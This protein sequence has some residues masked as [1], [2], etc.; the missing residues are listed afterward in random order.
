MGTDDPWGEEESSA[1]MNYDPSG[2]ANSTPTIPPPPNEMPP[3]PPVSRPKSAAP[4]PPL[5]APSTT[6]NSPMPAPV[7][8]VVNPA[9]QPIPSQPKGPSIF[10]KIFNGI[11]FEGMRKTMTSSKAII[12]VLISLGFL[13]LILS[14]AYSNSANYTNAPDIPTSSDFDLD[15]DGL[16]SAES[17]NYTNALEEYADDLDEHNDRM[18][19]HT[20][21]AI[22]WG[23]VSSAFIVGG[24]VGL[25]FS[26]K[27]VEMSNAVRLTLLIGTIYML[28]G[29]MGYELPGVDAAVGFGFGG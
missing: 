21:K 10:T 7:E 2:V 19:D 13:M 14:E 18:N 6:P 4:P 26:P 23:N 3:P 12:T 29:M 27:A 20:G 8:P 5:E 28:G 11:D 9:P 25:A 1:D 15:D 16:S 22:F 17:E 24:L